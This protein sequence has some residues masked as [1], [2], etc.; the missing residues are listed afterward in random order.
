MKNTDVE[1]RVVELP[2]RKNRT[3]RGVKVFFWIINFFNI[4]VTKRVEDVSIFTKQI[5]EVQGAVRGIEGKSKKAK[6]NID[7]SILA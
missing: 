4:F 2:K 7:F 6:N 3:L 1:G 5:F